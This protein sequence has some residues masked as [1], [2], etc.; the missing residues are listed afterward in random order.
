MDLGDANKASR[1][2][3]DL[4]DDED[5]QGELR[6]DLALAIDAFDP[7]F[8]VIEPA[9]QAAPLVLSSPHSGRKYPE[10]FLRASKLDGQTIRRSEDAY[11]DEIFADAPGLGLPF[12]CAEFPRVFLDV[13][14]EAFEL[15]PHLFEDPLP[16]F[17]NTT[18]HR[19]ACGLGTIA[20]V[21]SDGSEI[22]KERLSLSDAMDRVERLHKPYHQALSKLM[23][24]TRNRFGTAVLID[25]HSMPSQLSAEPIAL[26]RNRR[27][28]EIILGNR[29]GTSC[30]PMIIDE[31]ERQLR[32]FGYRVARNEPFAGGYCTEKYGDPASGFHSLQIE[33]S[34]G[35]YMRESNFERTE[36]LAR[37]RAQMKEVIGSL[38]SLDFGKLDLRG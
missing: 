19:V 26:R 20:R 9:V 21:V 7:P 11:V 30:D 33:I 34:R 35:L 2:L 12:L 3:P 4:W 25:C 15:D 27:P 32:R 18:S 14:R 28:A 37:L 5:A 6:S 1:P 24:A 13:N 38:A 16:G 22:Y 36:G 31:V 8:T 23:D 17:A 10:A 29:Y